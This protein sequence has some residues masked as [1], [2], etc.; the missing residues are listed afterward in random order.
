MSKVIRLCS[1]S[2]C[3]RIHASKGLCNTHYVR[4]RKTGKVSECI[5]VGEV[6]KSNPICSVVGCGG[7]SVCKSLC[8]GHY[9][10]LRNHGDLMVDKPISKSKIGAGNPKWRGGVVFD[11]GRAAVYSPD[12]P[13]PNFNHIYVYRYRLVMEKHLGRYLLPTEIVHH[14]NEDVTDDRL[15]NLEVMTQS[16]HIKLHLPEMRTDAWWVNFNKRQETRDEFGRFAA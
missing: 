12:H 3:G 5:P 13:Y 6:K 10:R 8:Q 4:L 9:V 15:D 14:K 11:H 7:K 1:V 16:E 2:R